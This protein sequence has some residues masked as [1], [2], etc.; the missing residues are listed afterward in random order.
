MAI[1]PLKHHSTQ[2]WNF[3]VKYPGTCFWGLNTK[4][5]IGSPS[6]LQIYYMNQPMYFPLAWMQCKC[7]G[8]ENLKQGRIVTWYRNGRAALFYGCNRQ[9]TQYRIQFLPVVANFTYICFTWWNTIDPQ[10]LP[11]LATRL[12]RWDGTKW[13]E[14]TISYRDRL[15]A[16]ENYCGVGVSG[17]PHETGIVLYDNTAIWA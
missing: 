11:K 14:G 7:P 2:D 15:T 4:L 12:D 6:S 17:S 5:F 8:A 16:N 9:G 3:L 1:K 13:I 10:N